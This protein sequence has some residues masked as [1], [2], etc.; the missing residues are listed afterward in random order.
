MAGLAVHQVLE[1]LAQKR[2]LRLK[3]PNDLLLD[4][5][6][7]AGMLLER[8]DGNVVLGIGINL[9]SAPDIEGRRTAAFA[10]GGQGAAFDPAAL[11]PDLAHMFA[12]A[13]ARWRGGPLGSIL[14]DW[15][16]RAHEP[17]AQL[18]VSM[19]PDEKLHGRYAGL[20]PDGA[21][22]LEV[23]DGSLREIRAADVEIVRE[24]S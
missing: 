11:M 7:C 9:A 4:G 10:D 20:A 16:D 14:A 18:A 12:D 21:L 6:K 2:D 8:E 13:L 1:P 3:W 23:A 22:M 15:Q 19:G 17:G 5:A 24:R